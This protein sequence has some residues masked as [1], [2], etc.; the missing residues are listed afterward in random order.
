MA[1]VGILG[2][3]FNPP[4]LAHLVCASEA[5]AQ[6]DLDRV[7]LTPVAV[8]PHKQAECDPGGAVRLELCRL[9]VAGDARL[10]VCDL[11]VARGGPS[12]TVDTLRELREREPEDHLTFILGGDIALGLPDWREPEAVLGLATLAIAERSGA[13][14]GEI[15]ELL[16]RAFPGSPAPRFFDMPRIDISSSQ[17]RRR[18]AGG[19]PIRYL[20]PDPVADRIEQKRLYR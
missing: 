9:A 19:R 16:E 17:I 1:R 14:R 6:L 3:T 20:V 15:A 12:Y 4:H 10:G 8:P 11:E 18:I 5:C 13:A 7:L 2:G